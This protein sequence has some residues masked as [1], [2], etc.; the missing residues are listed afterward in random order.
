LISGHRYRGANPILLTLAIFPRKGRK[1]VRPSGVCRQEAKRQTSVAE[2][3][4]GLMLK[5]TTRNCIE[6]GIQCW[7]AADRDQSLLRY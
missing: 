2:K 7:A 1:A 3:E 5:Y 4:T 6:S